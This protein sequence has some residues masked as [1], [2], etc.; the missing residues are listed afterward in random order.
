MTLDK[1]IT[2]A[3]GRNNANGP[4]DDVTWSEFR[5]QAYEIVGAHAQIVAY[6]SGSGV[7][8]D[9]EREGQG[10][11][12]A[13]ILAVNPTKPG[14][15]QAIASLLLKYG[16]SSACFAQDRAHRP[17]WATKSGNRAKARLLSNVQQY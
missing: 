7:G 13:V 9:D 14:L 6:T 8:S 5:T 16:Q 10:E 12:T 4:L 3:I 2:I 11:E 17:V 15:R 1:V